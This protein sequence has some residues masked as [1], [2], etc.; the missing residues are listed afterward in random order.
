MRGKWLIKSVMIW[1]VE[2]YKPFWQKQIHSNC[3]CRWCKAEANTAALVQSYHSFPQE[4]RHLMGIYCSK[5]SNSRERWSAKLILYP[6]LNAI[7]QSEEPTKS[8]HFSGIWDLLWNQSENFYFWPKLSR[9][10]NKDFE[11]T[12]DVSEIR[13]TKIP[14][15]L[16]ERGKKVETR[17]MRRLFSKAGKNRWKRAHVVFRLTVLLAKLLSLAC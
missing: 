16:L 1:N 9:K 8:L 6:L 3:I 5:P 2:F 17:E 7:S 12:A 10:Y 15:E 14:S 4:G 11:L 13:S